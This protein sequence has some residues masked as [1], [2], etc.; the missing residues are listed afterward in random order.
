MYNDL[1]MPLMSDV[2]ENLQTKVCMLSIIVTL[3]G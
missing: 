1:A 2:R 3:K